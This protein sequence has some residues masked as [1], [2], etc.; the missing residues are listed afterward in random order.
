VQLALSALFFA[1]AL[2][3]ANQVHLIK[4]NSKRK[5]VFELTARECV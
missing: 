1:R 4:S 5:K 2:K 3:I